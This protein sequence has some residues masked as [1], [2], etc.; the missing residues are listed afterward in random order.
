MPGKSGLKALQYTA[1]GIPTVATA[2][3]ANH[4]VIEDGVWAFSSRPSRT[5]STASSDWRP[6]PASRSASGALRASGWR[7]L[8]S[9][10][11]NEPVYLESSTA[12]SALE[13]GATVARL[14]E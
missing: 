10:K 14:W 8:Y 13:S 3:G 4:R 1:L 7:A 6:T 12:S 2:I 9:I 11:A 5:G